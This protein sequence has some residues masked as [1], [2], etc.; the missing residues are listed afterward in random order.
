[1]QGSRKT[2]VRLS[3]NVYCKQAISS[4]FDFFFLNT[5]TFLKSEAAYGNVPGTIR[6]KVV[7]LRHPW[8]TT[9]SKVRSLNKFFHSDPRTHAPTPSVPVFLFV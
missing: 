7:A 2:C 8:D 1:M 6:C 9:R 5:Q 4:F 3:T